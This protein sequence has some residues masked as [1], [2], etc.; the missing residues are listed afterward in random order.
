MGWG[1]VYFETGGGKVPAEEF[2]AAC[3]TTIKGRFYAVLGVVRDAPP[4]Q[5]GGGGYWE[6]MHGDMGGYYEIRLTGPGRRQYRLFCVLDNSNPS[7]LRKRGFEKPQIAAITGM[8]KASGKK[9]SERDYAKVRRLGD[10]Y[11]AELPR[12]IAG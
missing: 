4:P 6:A 12:R 10:E 2:L 1:I 7:G 3:P 11:A 9:F 8:I 5:F